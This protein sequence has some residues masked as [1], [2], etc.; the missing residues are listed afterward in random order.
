MRSL[1]KRMLTV[2][3]D[4]LCILLIVSGS[5]QAFAAPTIEDGVCYVALE[6]G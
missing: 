5:T 1:K 6:I 4:I 2:M 3:A